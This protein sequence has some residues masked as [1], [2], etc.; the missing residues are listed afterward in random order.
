MIIDRE[1]GIVDK[2]GNVIERKTKITDEEQA[3]MMEMECLIAEI[4]NGNGDAQFFLEVKNGQAEGKIEMYG[5]W[6][7]VGFLRFLKQVVYE[8]ELLN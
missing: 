6:E 7:R 5:S 3:S 1:A 2:V 4:G 8:M